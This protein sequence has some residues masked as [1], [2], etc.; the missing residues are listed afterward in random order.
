[1]ATIFFSAAPGTAL[2]QEIKKSETAKNSSGLLIPTNTQNE[3]VKRCLVI[4][5][6]NASEGLRLDSNDKVVVRNS[7][8]RDSIVFN[9]E[10][11]HIV[12]TEDVLGKIED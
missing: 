2:V 6:S 4:T 5:A 8:L 10:L 11:F 9:D 3:T 7:D 1:M 12:K